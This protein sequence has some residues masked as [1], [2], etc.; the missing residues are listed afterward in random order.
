MIQDVL[1]ASRLSPAA[2]ALLIGRLDQL[3]ASFDP[4]NARQRQ[5]VCV[6]LQIF[7]T[8]VRLQ[9]GK[10]ITHEQADE[11]IAAANRVRTALGC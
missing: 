9:A 11:W 10:T 8:A 6:A 3:L 5:A 7:K 4:G 1:D 2:K